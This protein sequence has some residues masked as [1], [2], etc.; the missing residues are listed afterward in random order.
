M[1][2]SDKRLE[3]YRLGKNLILMGVLVIPIL[4]VGFWV[5]KG[6]NPTGLLIMAVI[7]I[8]PGAGLVRWGERWVK[9]D[10]LRQ[11]AVSGE[12]Q[13]R[14]LLATEQPRPDDTALALP[15][16]IKLRP[17]WTP[18]ILCF[19]GVAIITFTPLTILL[20]NTPPAPFLLYVAVY[21]FFLLIPTLVA[22]LLPMLAWQTITV[23]DE[24]LRIQAEQPLKITWKDARL[25][26]IYP[27]NKPSQPPIRYELSGSNSI[28]RWKR[29]ARGASSLVTK[30]PDP[31]DEY[32]RQMDALL[33][34]IAA[35][36]GL[37]LYDLR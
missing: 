23:T 18:P 11:L 16:K 1:V 7:C 14:A 25:F 24:G 26:A 12:E 5:F 33:S 32:D 3:W 13:A 15:C 8:L 10:M 2:K 4:A 31:F 34:V 29:I 6:Q 19:L 27:A 28:V 9:L 17:K 36:T 37:P 20:L 22:S 21:G 30:I 35:K